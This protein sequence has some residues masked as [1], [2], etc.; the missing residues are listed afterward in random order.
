L[1]TDG[2]WR[3]SLSLHDALPIFTENDEMVLKAKG[4]LIGEGQINL[5]VRYFVNDTTGKFLMKGSI[6]AMNLA[7]L[8]KIIE[9]STKVTL[10]KGRINS[11]FFNI[12][13]DDIDGT[14]EVIVRYEDVEIEILDRNFGHNQNIFQR[15]GSFLANKLIVKSQNP[16]KKGELK[17]GAV[18][19]PRDQH[20]FIFKYWWELILSGL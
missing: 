8:N 19:Y 17:K 9:P 15:I 16:N 5:E 3:H 13:A 11:L 6:G 20:K 1:A 18:Y 4:R 10:K 14:G 12:V 2:N 7:G